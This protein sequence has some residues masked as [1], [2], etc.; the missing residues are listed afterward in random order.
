MGLYL[1]ES[2]VIRVFREHRV[3][4]LEVLLE[5]LL[6][7]LPGPVAVVPEPSVETQRQQVPRV[8]QEDGLEEG[9]GLP[10]PLTQHTE[11]QTALGKNGS[12]IKVAHAAEGRQ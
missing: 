11:L 12:S 2:G 10:A 4:V 8:L 1:D 3:T 7:V 6:P 5:Q 9:G